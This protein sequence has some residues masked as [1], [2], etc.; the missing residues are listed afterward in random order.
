MS[1]NKDSDESGILVK[2]RVKKKG[3]QENQ[4]PWS[5]ASLKLEIRRQKIQN[6]KSKEMYQ[7]HRKCSIFKPS[8]SRKNIEVQGKTKSLTSC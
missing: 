4:I 6:I 1:F 5:G 3:K 7:M 8:I 2:L